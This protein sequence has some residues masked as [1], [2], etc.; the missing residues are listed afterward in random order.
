MLYNVNNQVYRLNPG[1]SSLC[2]KPLRKFV[3]TS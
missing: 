1:S 2:S 3:Q